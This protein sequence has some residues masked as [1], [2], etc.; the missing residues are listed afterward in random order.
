M[1]ID[2]NLARSELTAAEESAY[3]LRRKAVWD[4]INKTLGG[5]NFPTQKATDHKDRPQNQKQFASEVA[6]VT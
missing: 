2:E 5:Q 4:E 1:E 6:S 3:I